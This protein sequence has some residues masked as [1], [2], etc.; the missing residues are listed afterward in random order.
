MKQSTKTLKNTLIYKKNTS[1]YI[2][3][4]TQI[5]FYIWIC[6]IYD[7]IQIC[8]WFGDFFG[9]FNKKM[10]KHELLRSLIINN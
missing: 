4:I 9:L 7:V 5:K 6:I 10:H 2:V 1:K 3:V 8:S